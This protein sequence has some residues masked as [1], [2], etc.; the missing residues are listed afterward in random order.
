MERNRLKVGKR[1]NEMTCNWWYRVYIYASL[2]E[3]PRWRHQ[4]E[5][6]SALLAIC[7]GNSPVTGEFPAHRPVTQSFDIFFHLRLNE[8][9]SKQ[10][11][12]WWFETPSL[13]LWRHSNA[14]I[15]RLFGLSVWLCAICCLTHWGRVTHIC[16]LTAPSH[17]LTQPT[18]TINDILVR[19]IQRT[20]C[21]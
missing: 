2:L 12:D 21:F 18:F 10:S 11:S 16:W 4:M 17:H 13:P 1:G 20:A 14:Y 7:A 15:C 9:S 3:I 6:F 19:P 8:R 5:T